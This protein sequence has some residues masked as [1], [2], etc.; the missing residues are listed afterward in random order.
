[1][2]NLS[3]NFIEGIKTADKALDLYNRHIDRIVPWK[4]FNETLVELDRF[5][6]NYS[7]ESA[8]LIGDVKKLMMDGMDAYFAASQNVYEVTLSLLFY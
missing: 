4:E 2:T 5:R 3:F 8:A 7:V 1:M 6:G